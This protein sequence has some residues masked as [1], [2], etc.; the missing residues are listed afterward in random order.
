M[1]LYHWRK[2]FAWNRDSHC[3]NDQLMPHVEEQKLIGA[4][5][6]VGWQETLQRRAY[7]FDRSTL[8]LSVQR[9]R[10]GTLAQKF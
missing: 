5:P 6:Y 1:K 8:L 10:S 9:D 7:C 2:P 4:Y 3:P